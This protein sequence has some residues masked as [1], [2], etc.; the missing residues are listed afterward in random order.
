LIDRSIARSVCHAECHHGLES[1]TD[2]DPGGWYNDWLGW[3][4]VESLLLWTTSNNFM[5][6]LLRV[7]PPMDHR[8]LSMRIPSGA[9]AYTVPM[10]LCPPGV[11][12][13]RWALRYP[14]KTTGVSLQQ[15]R[16]REMMSRFPKGA[17]ATKQIPREEMMWV[18]PFLRM[19][20]CRF[21]WY[22]VAPAYVPWN[23][24]DVLHARY[25]LQLL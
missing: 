12:V 5:I 14:K 21:G 19:R 20:P 17:A 25:Q 2:F 6:T 3:K 24:M 23:R 15:E 7:K 1:A 8:F 13:S 4:N 11:S 10:P 16:R 22:F 18:A 9:D